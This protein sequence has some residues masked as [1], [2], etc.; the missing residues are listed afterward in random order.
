MS[1]ILPTP[2]SALT[3]EVVEP[4]PH[5]WLFRSSLLD[6]VLYVHVLVMHSCLLMVL[7]MSAMQLTKFNYYRGAVNFILHLLARI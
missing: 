6:L 4:G 5:P 2:T 3:I 7:A 1:D